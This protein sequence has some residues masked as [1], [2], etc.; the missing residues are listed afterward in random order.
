MVERKGRESGEKWTPQELR[1]A[2]GGKII[3]MLLD[4]WSVAKMGHSLCEK[5]VRAS[6]TTVGT[7]P[8]VERWDPNG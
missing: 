3:F 7:E 1:F 4:A 5:N 6:Q 2:T 8:P